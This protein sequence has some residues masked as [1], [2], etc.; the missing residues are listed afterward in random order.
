MGSV[1][2]F[3]ELGR[4]LRASRSSGAN[5]LGPKAGFDGQEP[6]AATIIILPVIR[7]ERYPEEPAEPDSSRTPRRRR[8]RRVSRT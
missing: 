5:R 3:P 1:I 6:E 4:A 8:R 2:R 7:I